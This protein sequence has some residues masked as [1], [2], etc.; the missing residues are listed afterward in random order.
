LEGHTGSV[1]SVAFSPDGKQIV[2][3]SS[4]HTVRIW[5]VATEEAVAAPL[6]SYTSPSTLGAFSPDCDQL[7]LSTPNSTL[8]ILDAGA[9]KFSSNLAHPARLN[10]KH[11]ND[12]HSIRVSSSEYYLKSLLSSPFHLRISQPMHIS[13]FV[14][15]GS[16]IHHLCF[17]GFQVDTDQD[18]GTQ[19]TQW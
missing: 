15:A 7:V 16:P 12:H 6:E 10:I 8:P 17:S 9:A 5:G 19:I 4:D 18:F 1:Y 13:R 14:K 3:G 2:S 11:S